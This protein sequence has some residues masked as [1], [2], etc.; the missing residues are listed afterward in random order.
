[1]D[2]YQTV[3][4]VTGALAK[5]VIVSM[6]LE[7][8]LS[9][10]FEHEWFVRATT[11]EV[12]DPLDENKKIRENRIPGLKASLSILA[13]YFVCYHYNFDML[14]VVLTGTSPKIFDP[15]GV[16]LT[17]LIVS[18][19]SAGA[20][21]IFQGYLNLSKQGRDAAVEARKSNMEAD[22]AAAVARTQAVSGGNL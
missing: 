8:G 7:R 22:K 16:V 19:G 1:M 4:L 13:S 3:L 2:N 10:I 18:G 9:V 5:L 14:F 6:V 17:S 11:K 20:I 15:T 21:L 12:K